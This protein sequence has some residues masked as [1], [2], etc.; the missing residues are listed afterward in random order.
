MKHRLFIAAAASALVAACTPPPCENTAEGCGPS[1]DAP[2]DLASLYGDTTLSPEA[3]TIDAQQALD[4]LQILASDT[5]GG[6]EA[7]T[8]GNALARSYITERLTSMGVGPM[9]E[10]FDH[11]FD[12]RLRVDDGQVHTGINILAL[13]EG[14]SDSDRLMVVSAH[15]DHVGIREGEVYN[16]AD[17]NASG[18]AGVLAVAAEFMANPPEHDVILAFF[19]AEERGLQGARAFVM[20][21]P[22]DQ[23]RITFNLNFDMIAMSDERK[24]WAVGTYHY[25]SLKPLVEQVAADAP[26]ELPMGFDEPT[27][28]PGGDWTMLSD[29]GAFHAVGIPIIY[30]GVDF[31]PHYHQAT[32]EFENMTLDFFQDAV[33]TSVRFA[34]VMD[35]ALDTVGEAEG[36]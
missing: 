33:E 27:D 26:V 23:D 15:Y 21:P 4:D 25:P 1:A 11:P 32:D 34:V 24:L 14:T 9:G 2:A 8:E 7:G 29:Q 35:E 12:Y 17:D 20:D 13:I 28:E 36:R 30:L 22:V 16:G 10:G 6:R 19:D 31:H 5:M 18:V 3:T